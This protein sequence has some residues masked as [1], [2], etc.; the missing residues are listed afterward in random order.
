MKPSLPD[1]CFSCIHYKQAGYR[2]DE[3]APSKDRFGF[4]CSPKKQRFGM[5]QEKRCHVFWNESKC[6]AYVQEPDCDTH[7]CKPR[8]KALEPHQDRLI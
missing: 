6:A 5:C 7:P 2:E 1:T 8:P 3:F 4:D